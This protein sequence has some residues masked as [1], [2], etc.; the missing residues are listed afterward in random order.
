MDTKPFVS[1]SQPAERAQEDRY[2][3]LIPAYKPDA[4]MLKLVRELRAEGLC[5]QV[6][7]DGSG[8]TYRDIF[9]QAQALGCRVARH[10]VNLGKGRALKTGINAAMN[11][12][13][14][15]DGIVT[16]DADGQHTCRDILRIMA[17]MRE[18]PRALI[19]GARAFDGNIPLKSRLGNSI[20]RRVYHF[21]TGIRCQDTQT[22][23]RGIPAAYLPQ[24]LQLPGERYEYEMT[25]FLRLREMRLPLEEVTIE[26]IYIDGNKGSHFHPL[27]DSAR[28]YSV[29][30]RF[31]ASSLISFGVDYGL[32]WLL[33]GWLD[34][35]PWLCYAFARVVSSGVNYLLNRM[36]VFKTGGRDAVFR[37]YLLAV[38]QLS[39]GA[40]L[41]ELL[42]V[43]LHW[44]A[45][46]IKIPVDVVL[47]CLSYLVQRD[48]VFK[49]RSGQK[50]PV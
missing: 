36:T 27:K 2:V 3:V 7:D 33:L 44:S 39:V 6:V 10:A 11:A 23:L 31:L 18:N 30:L 40:G 48:F 20:T 35:P 47:F 43:T 1:P 46:W 8:E 37:Y 21:A 24:M 16:A 17:R 13:S 38:T 9:D 26:T 34:L 49:E 42:H 32:Y 41:V 22:G 28:I 19:T 15:L 25:M 12:F 50:E 29:I 45:G 4:R 14:P 5:V